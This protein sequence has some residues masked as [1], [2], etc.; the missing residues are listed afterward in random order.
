MADRVYKIVTDR[1]VNKR[2]SGA[3]LTA[4]KKKSGAASRASR[5][6]VRALQLAERL[7]TA[8]RSARIAGQEVS[9]DE[10]EYYVPPAAELNAM[11]C[12][13]SYTV[14]ETDRP[15]PPQKDVRYFICILI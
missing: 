7:A 8:K 15:E 6:N 2:I 14:V 3:I 13:P 9:D 4:K 10:P 12:E 11:L 1:S 5:R